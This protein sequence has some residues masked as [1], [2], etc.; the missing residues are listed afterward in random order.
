MAVDQGVSVLAR[1]AEP[2]DQLFRSDVVSGEDAATAR[3]G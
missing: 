1:S 2:A 3:F